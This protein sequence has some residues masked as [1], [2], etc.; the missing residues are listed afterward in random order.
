V[1]IDELAIRRLAA[2]PDVVGDQLRH[3]ADAGRSRQ[4]VT[5]RVL[6]LGADIFG[7]AVPRS[8]F[9]SYR[10]PD[11]G[12]PVIVAVDT[13]TS[14]L[15]LTSDNE[16]NYYLSMYERLRDSSLTPEDSHEFLT[17]VAQQLRDTQR[18]AS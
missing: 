6:P 2:S 12:D 11:P 18:S 1:I 10:Y 4:K 14:D 7:Y 17:S 13:V 3:I 5:V 16:V 8:A 15:V 9:S